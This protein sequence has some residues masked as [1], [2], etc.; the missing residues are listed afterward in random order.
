M[1]VVRGLLLRV[2]Y[3]LRFAD[4]CV[5]CAI[6]W[7]LF[8]VRFFLLVRIVASRASRVVCCWLLDVVACGM[9]ASVCDVF[10]VRCLLSVVRLRCVVC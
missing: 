3:C 7:S 2:V 8:D 9:F 5:V 10:G 1:F 4:N 6:Y